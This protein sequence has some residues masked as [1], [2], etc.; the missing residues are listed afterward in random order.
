[1][2]VVD[3]CRL[4]NRQNYGEIQ[5]PLRTAPRLWKRCRAVLPNKQPPWRCEADV[6][7]RAPT[8]VRNVLFWTLLLMDADSLYQQW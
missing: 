2:T 8:L 3:R 6:V 1:V 7:P 4:F 5:L